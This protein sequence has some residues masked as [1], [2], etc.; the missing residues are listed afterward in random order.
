MAGGPALDATPPRALFAELVAG[1]L[2]QTGVEPSPVAVQYL[3]G[4]LHER[5]RSAPTPPEGAETLA[6]ALLSARL[7]PGSERLR[8]LRGIGDRALFVAGFFRDSLSRGAVGVEYYGDV[9][10][11]AYAQVA[12]ALPA[13]ARSSPSWR[14]LFGELAGRFG[15][16]IE[17]LCEVGDRTRSQ[18]PGGLLALYA[19]YLRTGGERERRR[20]LR[21]GLAATLST[22]PRTWQ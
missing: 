1:A 19:S 11:T 4:L 15:D 9:G 5:V 18:R 8:R 21:R 7:V 22:D 6:E 2:G 14:A 3:V 10:R 16:F 20:L 17:V 12:A 13:D